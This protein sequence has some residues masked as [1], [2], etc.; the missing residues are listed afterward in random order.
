MKYFVEGVKKDHAGG[1][2]VR[3]IGEFETLEIAILASQKVIEHF[4]HRKV[5]PGMTAADLFVQYKKSGVVPVI[6]SDDDRTMNVRGFNHFKFALDRCTE[7]CADTR[8]E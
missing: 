8:D 2:Q 7:I 3:R 6:F 1:N 5:K 4:L